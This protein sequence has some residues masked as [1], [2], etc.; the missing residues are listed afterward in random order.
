[1]TSLHRT[2][3]LPALLGTV[4]LASVSSASAQQPAP[5]QPVAVRPAPAVVAPCQGVK[6][7]A[8]AAECR[9]LLSGHTLMPQ[10]VAICGKLSPAAAAVTC[11]QAA[12][13]RQYSADALDWCSRRGTADDTAQCFSLTG[14]PS[15]AADAPYND[16]PTYPVRQAQPPAG[17]AP[18]SS[19]VPGPATDITRQPL[20]PSS[21]PRSPKPEVVRPPG[22]RAP[23][24]G[25]ERVGRD[26]RGAV[27]SPG[28]DW[29]ER[30]GRDVRGGA[31]TVGGTLRPRPTN[32]PAYGPGP[33]QSPPGSAPPQ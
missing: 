21:N 12:V 18:G 33:T 28:G 15:R 30:V 2:G 17:Q 5:P 4:T 10:V 14:G 16:T 27:E 13:D 26:V 3:F 24:G 29:L 31:E 9:G 11:L 32:D 19:G 7:P 25:I 22:T 1:M 23:A 6:D 20:S 8:V